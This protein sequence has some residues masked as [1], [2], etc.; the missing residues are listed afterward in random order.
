[1]SGHRLPPLA[2]VRAFEA[3]ARL[4]SF[5]LAAAE[6]GMSQAA[7]SYQIK[8]LEERLGVPLFLRLPRR[9]ELTDSGKRL[10]TAVTE[11]FD[12]LQAAFAELHEKAQGILRITVV[13][14]F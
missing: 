13:H 11:A 3:A 1:M 14:T 12:W 4:G 7:I 6:L 10:S 9:A 2:A 8:R 5:T